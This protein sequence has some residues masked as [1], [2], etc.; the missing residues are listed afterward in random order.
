[1][2]KSGFLQ[3]QK[4]Q[5]QLYMDI[6]ERIM[7]QFKVLGK[8]AQYRG[9]NI[10][11]LATVHLPEALATSENEASTDE[12]SHQWMD[13]KGWIYRTAYLQD[14]AGNIYK[15]TLN[16]ANGRD[17]KILYDITNIREIDTKKEATG[18]VVPS[19]N[20]GR[21]SHTSDGFKGSLPNNSIHVK[22]KKLSLKDGREDLKALRS[23]RKEVRDLAQRAK[24]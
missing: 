17:R 3:R 6:T 24:K 7:K 11:A 4:Q 9:D 21:D 2:N 5:Q 19:T 10:R 23:E 14:R 16:I 8:L 1:M 20:T 13:E 22:G 12:H 15:A 18:G